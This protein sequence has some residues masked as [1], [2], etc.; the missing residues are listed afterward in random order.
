MPT[1]LVTGP[2]I[3]PLTVKEAKDHLRVDHGDDDSYIEPLI[4][5]VRDHAE[6]YTGRSLITQTWD[7]WVN[8]FPPN[9][10]WL[11]LPLPP[12]Q[13]VTSVKYT[14]TDGVQ[15][16]LTSS[17]YTVDTNAEAGRITLAYNESWPT[18]RDVPNAVEIRFVSGYGA[19]AQDVPEGIRHAMRMLLGHFYER[20][21]TTLVGV[22]IVG[23]PQSYEWLLTPYRVMR[24]A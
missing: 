16:T 10:T 9:G 12:L 15:Q 22:P 8:T 13:S 19:T 23:V 6:T 4:T 14:D 2:A 3:E 20:R 21:E 5:A 7:Y 18:V 17:V 11:E 1:N 24:F